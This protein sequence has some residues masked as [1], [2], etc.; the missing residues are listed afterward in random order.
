MANQNSGMSDALRLSFR[1]G[2]Q[3]FKE[4]DYGASV[5]RVIS[6]EVELFT[7]AGG[8]EM[9]T[10]TLGPGSL[11]GEMVFAMPQAPRLE[12]ARA[13]QDTE[14]QV[15]HVEG[16]SR[17]LKKLSPFLRYVF[18]QPLARVKRTGLILKQL[19]QKKGA[20]PQPEAEAVVEAAPKE[21]EAE[22][23]ETTTP[24]EVPKAGILPQGREHHLRV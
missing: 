2:E 1:K 8:I 5:Y 23:L 16:L 3:I 10:D 4:G 24:L 18:E 17:E 6:G 11:V 13:D 15:W 7:D 22:K 9:I 12:S 14:L 19:E 20:G 21:K